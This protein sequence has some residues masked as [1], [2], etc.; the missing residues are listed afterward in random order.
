M[1]N[2]LDA[3]R[4]DLHIQ[5]LLRRKYLKRL[6]DR[7]EYQNIMLQSS[8]SGSRRYYYV[9]S[10]SGQRVYLG[11][12][13]NETLQL[14]REAR[15]AAE[16]VSRLDQNIGLLQHVLDNYL[17]C[18]PRDIQAS[19]PKTYRLNS[20]A[21]PI[22]LT[23]RAA[24]WLEEKKRIKAAHPVKDPQ[25]LTVVAF[26]GTPMRSRMETLEYDAF[27]IHNIPCSYECPLEIHGRLYYPDFTLLRTTDFR[28]FLWEHLGLWFHS[29][30][31]SEYRR[32]TI[33]KFDD[34]AAAGY[35]PEINVLLS[36]EPPDSPCDLSVL[37]QKIDGIFGLPPT[38]PELIRL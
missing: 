3:I 12:E 15:F 11:G 26:D 27:Y 4:M 23:D 5:K 32:N 36:F 20:L 21:L 34:Y 22:S 8:G 9:R 17:S 37:H 13:Q 2:S 18:D 31:K 14:I 25:S 33:Q 28:E 6:D 29:E 24:E 7:S 38:E 1:F 35:Y 16:A 19:L 30:K 10:G